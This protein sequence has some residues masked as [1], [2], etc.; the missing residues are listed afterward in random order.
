MVARHGH[1]LVRTHSMTQRL[2]PLHF[3][4]HVNGDF[5]HPNDHGYAAIA[6]AFEATVLGALTGG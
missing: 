2:Y 3:L 5:F 4:R 6:T 1:R